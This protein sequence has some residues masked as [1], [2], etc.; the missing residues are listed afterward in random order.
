VRAPLFLLLV[1]L[2]ACAKDAPQDALQP[3]G[4]IAEQADNL[5]RPV[6]W[7]ATAI[8]VLVEGLVIVVAV[9]FR[10]KRADQPEPKQIHGNTKLELGWTLAPALLLLGVA[11]PTVITIQDLAAPPAPDAL[12]VTVTGKQWWWE[13]EYPE[14]G[15]VTANELVIP[16]DREVFLQ[17]ESADVIHSFWVPR[18][19]GKQDV[20]PE[21]TNTMRLIAVEAGQTYLGQC[22]EFCAISH[23]N[24]RLRVD[25]LTPSGFDAWVREQQQPAPEPVAG[26]LEARGRELFQSNACIQCHATQVGGASLG[27]NLAHLASRD[28]F[29][30]A[31]FEL[32]EENLF[33]WVQDAPSLKP[34]HPPRIE[35]ND[36]TALIEPANKGMPSFLRILSEGEIRAIVA[37]LL[38]LN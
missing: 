9:K 24:M 28:F 38:S 16:I 8:F 4:P 30:G 2:A 7:I 31:T 34:M 12:H 6:F 37:Y 15:I 26:S 17:L 10:Q 18:L 36:P 23:A 33:K 21:R 25:T 22:A 35:P 32:N 5:F 27:P 3:A 29:A 20:V 1:F 14:Q 19:A 13:F 11:I